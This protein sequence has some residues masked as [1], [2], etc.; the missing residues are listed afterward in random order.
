MRAR[1][2]LRGAV[3]LDI[4]LSREG[5]RLGQI[6]HGAA[7]SGMSPV[8]CGAARAANYRQDG[9]SAERSHRVPQAMQGGSGL[10]TASLSHSNRTR[11]KGFLDTAKGTNPRE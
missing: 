2:S 7:S 6:L 8:P 1:R 11:D 3:R 9:G 4:P 10:T 5:F